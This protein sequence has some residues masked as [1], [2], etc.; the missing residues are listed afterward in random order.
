MLTRPR[1]VPHAKDRRQRLVAA[2]VAL[3]LPGLLFLLLV[4]PFIPDRRMTT[5]STIFFLP[6]P[7]PDPV[8]IDARGAPRREI[9][10]PATPLPIAPANPG[11]LPLYAQPPS[12]QALLAALR[13]ALACKME[14]FGQS[15]A[16]ASCPTLREERRDAALPGR[17]R[18]ETGWAEA[19]ASARSPMLLPCFS[20][21]RFKP[22]LGCAMGRIVNGSLADPSTWPD[23]YVRELPKEE[24]ARLRDA[25][26][27]FHRQYGRAARGAVTLPA[28]QG[29]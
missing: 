4:Q 14:Q 28:E 1:H 17:V 7:A 12:G 11:E 8:T 20:G 25:Y 6:R 5:G 13:Y 27:A 24:L 21:N 16:L 23:Q 9:E 26:A 3:A 15:F 29:K 2:V 19:W 10:A 22:D 18:D